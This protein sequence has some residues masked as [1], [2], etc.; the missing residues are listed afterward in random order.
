CKTTRLR[1]ELPI[2][3]PER[4]DFGPEANTSLPLAGRSRRLPVRHGGNFGAGTEFDAHRHDSIVDAGQAKPVVL[5]F[6]ATDEAVRAIWGIR[7][8]RT[9]EPVFGNHLQDA[10]FS[11]RGPNERLQL[12]IPGPG[13]DRMVVVR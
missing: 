6:V 2:L 4:P 13:V 11:D 5:E 7:P 8:G 10:F 1:Q 3:S 9:V 12:R